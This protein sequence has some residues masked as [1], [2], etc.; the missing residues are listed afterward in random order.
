SVTPYVWTTSAGVTVKEDGVVISDNDVAFSDL[1]SN[2]DFAFSFHAEGRR[3]R[4]GLL[5]DFFYVDLSTSETV[6]EHQNPEVPPPGS[7]I[8]VNIEQLILE[9]GGFYRLSGVE[10]GLDLLFGL[11]W[12]GMDEVIN[13]TLP[14]PPNP[15]LTT[16]SSP[17]LTDGFLGLRYVGQIGNK[18]GYSIRG[19]VA[20]G[21]TELT[22]NGQAFFKYQIGQSGKYGLLLGYR[23]MSLE[24][25]ERVE[26]V[27]IETDL[28]YSGPVFGSM[29]KW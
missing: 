14:L 7:M 22:L 18:W 25:E 6:P 9:G 29:F 24:I 13:V 1:F 27:D 12:I 26:G 5:F 11:R 8:D 4:A 28:T 21:D 3:G 23:Y 20:T 15:T 19:D 10:T 16:K 2:L 17:N